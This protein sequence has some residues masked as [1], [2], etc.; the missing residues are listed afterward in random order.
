MDKLYSFFETN[1]LFKLDAIADKATRLETCLL[2]RI[3]GLEVQTTFRT[4]P[5]AE[6]I[7]SEPKVKII[8]R[9]V[10]FFRLV[11]VV[12]EML[13]LSEVW[14]WGDRPLRPRD[15]ILPRGNT[16]LGFLLGFTLSLVLNWTFQA[17]ATSFVIDLASR[18]KVCGYREIN[19]PG[20]KLAW[21]L[22][23]YLFLFVLV[24]VV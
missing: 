20:K 24:F 18:A 7:P 5:P 3:P 9:F 17:T 6:L 12:S 10:T 11:G 1:I 22:F 16:F 2:K 13:W 4:F 14:S 21:E 15:Y 23:K 8:I 19:I